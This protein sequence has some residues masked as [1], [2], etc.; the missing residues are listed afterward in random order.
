MRVV[1]WTLFLG[2]AFGNR[3]GAFHHEAVAHGAGIARGF[4]FNGVLAV[5]VPRTGIE[6]TEASP[7]LNHLT[8]LADR[9]LDAA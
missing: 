8:F 2:T 5:W 4:G 9:A 7:S 3:L 6:D 1:I